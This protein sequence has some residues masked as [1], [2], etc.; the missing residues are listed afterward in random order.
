[1]F[2]L[3][4]GKLHEH[5]DAKMRSFVRG[6][7][8][9]LVEEARWEFTCNGSIAV[10]STSTFSDIDAFFKTISD[11]VITVVA[12]S[13]VRLIINFDDLQL[14]VCHNS[15]SRGAQLDD[16]VYFVDGEAAVSMSETLEVADWYLT[17]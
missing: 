16:W 3:E 15:T 14:V 10:S 8:G 6:E 7:F 9:L 2:Y 5:F 17:G 13:N 4:I 12:L 11:K 1:M